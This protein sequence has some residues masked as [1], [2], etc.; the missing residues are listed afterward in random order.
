MSA[1]SRV[2]LLEAPAALAVVHRL[3]DEGVEVE[4]G[5]GLAGRDD[6]ERAADGHRVA[7]D[8]RGG[9]VAAELGAAE[10]LEQRELDGQQRQPGEQRQAHAGGE[11]QQDE[12]RRLV[13]HVAGVHVGGLVG[14]HGAAAVVVED[15]HEL[16]VED[17]DRPVD[18]DRRRVGERE[19]RQV[20]VGHVLEVERVE[21]LAVQHPDVRAAGPGRDARRSRARR[22]AARARSPAR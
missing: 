16:G 3:R 18:P 10:P 7:G 4:V 6:H 19:L 1:I 17:H 11:P 13:E 14:Q 8:E 20:E 22:R 9:A 15:P 12:H 21:A 5:G 2:R